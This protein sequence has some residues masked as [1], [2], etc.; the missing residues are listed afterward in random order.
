MRRER[1]S[2]TW[3]FGEWLERER[4]TEINRRPSRQPR[5]RT[6]CLS[7]LLSSEA[8]CL[9]T[10]CHLHGSHTFA[11]CASSENSLSISLFLFLLLFLF[12]TII[13]GRGNII[14]HSLSIS[15]HEKTAFQWE[16]ERER[17]REMVEW[18]DGLSQ[19]ALSILG[20]LF[21]FFLFWDQSDKV[22]S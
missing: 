11:H 2:R 22:Y 18:K 7:V 16:R 5:Q 14:G 9:F 8:V 6:F 10:A 4:E 15:S 21:P 1:G 19:T 3:K 20:L 17:E 12:G 13:W